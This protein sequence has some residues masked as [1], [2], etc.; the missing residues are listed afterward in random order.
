MDYSLLPPPKVR[1][2]AFNLKKSC[3]VSYSNSLILS[4]VAKLS[5]HKFPRYAK[6][7]GLDTP[8]NM[9]HTSK[10]LKFHQHVIFKDLLYSNK[11][12]TL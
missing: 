5:R 1:E 8:E 2:N 7:C 10:K 12:F 6:F 4:S 9:E 3:L 11:F